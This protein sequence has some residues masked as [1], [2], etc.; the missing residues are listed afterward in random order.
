MHAQTQ[1]L[2]I[3]RHSDAVLFTALVPEFHPSCAVQ[4]T[5]MEV[6]FSGLAQRKK[7]WRITCLDQK[8][9]EETMVENGVRVAILRC[10]AKFST[11]PHT[12]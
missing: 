11:D 3:A 12:A 9:L 6:L 5:I 7:W 4:C 1:H 2:T 8:M 10:V